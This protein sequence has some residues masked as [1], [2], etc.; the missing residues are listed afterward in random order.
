MLLFCCHLL[1]CCVFEVLSYSIYLVMDPSYSVL[2]APKN[3]DNCHAKSHGN[4]AVKIAVP[5]VIILVLA[6]VV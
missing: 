5:I 1:H 4:R 3:S 2:V 6:V